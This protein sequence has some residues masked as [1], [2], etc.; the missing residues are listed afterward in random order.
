MLEVGKPIKVRASQSGAQV[1][2]QS[3]PGRTDRAA[4]NLRA[5][6]SVERHISTPGSSPFDEVQWEKREASITDDKGGVLFQQKDVEVP[7]TWSQLATNVV[8]SKYFYGSLQTGFREN[9]V[10]QLIHRVARTIADWGLTGGYFASAQDADN[11]YNELAYICLNQM[12]SF[13]SPVWFNVGL[14]HEY[15]ISSE[16]RHSFRW[17]DASGRIVP[18]ADSYRNPQASACF[19]QAVQDTMED[20]MRLA[21]SEAMLFKYGSGTGTDL[22]T[23]RSRRER[24]SGGGTPSGPLSF[25]RVYDQVAAVVKSGGKTRRAAKMQSLKVTHPDIHDFITAKMTEEKKAWALID[26]GYDG[27]FGGDAYSSVMFQ[28][29]NFS[30]RVT[31]DFMQAVMEDGEWETR[32]VT[33]GRPM[34]KYRARE[35]M[36]LIAE[37][38]HLCG[39]PGLQYDTTINKWHTCLASGR[40]NA[41]NPCSE[42]MFLDDSACN[43]SSLNLMKFLQEDGTFDVERFGHAVRIMIIAQEILV[44]SGSYPTEQIAQNSHDYRPLGLGYA[45]LGAML[46]SLGMPYDSS[47]G[48]AYASAVTA[49][50]TGYAYEA[51]SELA[52]V[53]GPFPV[54]APNREC[55]LNVLQMHRAA[56]DS[57]DTQEAPPSLLAAASAAWARVA[58]VG[59]QNGFRNAQV[60]LLA[61][62]GTI[63]F[64][65]DCDT[66]GIEP[67]I[68]L[69][70]YKQLAGGGMM[71]LV[72][73]SVST[74]LRRLG[75]DD[76]AAEAIVTY[77]DEQDTIENAPH[78]DQKDLQVFDCAFK[79]RQGTRCIPY[80]AHLRMMSA[81]Q[82]FLSGAISKTINMPSEATVDEILQAYIDGW[83]L[84]LKAVAIYRDGSKR[85][86]PVNTGPGARAAT[87]A[88][89]ATAASP[90]TPGKPLRRRMP[91]TRHS[92]THKFEVAG[93]EGYLTVGLYEDGMPGEL[94]ITMAK[95]G[96]TVGGIMDSFGTA[97]SLCLQYG[98]PLRELIKKFSHSRFEPSGFT[99]NPDIPIAKSL[100]DYI[101]RWMALTFPDGRAT[102][103]PPVPVSGLVSDA[104]APAAAEPAA[105]AEPTGRIDE[106]FQHFMEDAPACDVCG[107]ITVRNGACYKCYNCGN[108]MGCS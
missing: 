34:E 21:S 107:A 42:F 12:G 88:S 3:S 33:S 52:G 98:V 71:K 94:F 15:G 105:A 10:R 53:K 50:L 101:F 26:A 66:T 77:I 41:S 5:R 6:L 74:A 23:L 11:F 49:L 61:P 62:T 40:I 60:T 93:H 78:L 44:D 73:R 68:A 7:R 76:A 14:F 37:S 72:N 9:S 108:S 31:D 97:I 75:Y 58:D 47:R 91:A 90:V 84:G 65:M 36:Q 1:L 43:L 18:G 79:P 100:V 103:A 27:S 64:M 67:D 56:L 51:S 95:E 32:A 13:N 86:Q 96:S 22:S 30:V 89:D 69:V 35:L 106:Q 99:K 70:K 17:E 83:H 104:A 24:L 20:I 16:S 81:V 8:A 57:I 2:P 38:T 4:D 54:F 80:Q 102:A 39:D 46:M 48:R 85:V 92:I 55:M 63:G 19:I 82:P 59:P 28:N 87:A 45:N 25:M 29:S